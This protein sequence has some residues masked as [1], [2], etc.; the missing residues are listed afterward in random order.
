MGTL[1]RESE[2]RQTRFNPTVSPLGFISLLDP[3]IQRLQN[4][5]IDRGDHVHRRVQLFFGHT[6]FP[7]V[8]KAAI[9]S[10][11]A[12]PHHCDCQSDEHLLAACEALDSV[13][14]AVEGSKVGFFHLIASQTEG[15]RML[16]PADPK[17]QT[18][19]LVPQH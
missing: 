5:S 3:L 8:R 6:C 19:A 2:L 9:H 12:E 17:P 13:R 15:R 4:S 16:R 1:F 11:I 14:V 18:S 7:C 10:R